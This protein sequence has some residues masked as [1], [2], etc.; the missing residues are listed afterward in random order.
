MLFSKQLSPPRRLLLVNT[1]ERKKREATALER[2]N[3]TAGS[4]MAAG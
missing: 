1:S 3:E 2:E 4:L